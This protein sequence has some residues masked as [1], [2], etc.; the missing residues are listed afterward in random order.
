[1]DFGQALF[2]CGRQTALIQKIQARGWDAEDFFRI[3]RHFRKQV[4]LVGIRNICRCCGDRGKVYRICKKKQSGRYT[5]NDV[6]TAWTEEIMRNNVFLIG[7]MGA[8]KSTIARTLEQEYQ[9]NLVEMD[10]QIEAEQ[11]MK[12]SEIFQVRRSPFPCPCSASWLRRAF[13]CR[14][15]PRK[16]F[17]PDSDRAAFRG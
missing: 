10:E 16:R 14:P 11:G 2:L 6:R 1:M 17:R 15:D 12:I 4:I 3:L 5:R 7:F 8:G 13:P 9:M